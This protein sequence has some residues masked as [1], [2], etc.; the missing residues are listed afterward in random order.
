MDYTVVSQLSKEEYLEWRLYIEKMFHSEQKVKNKK[1][2]YSLMDKD[3]ELAKM[4]LFIFK[5]SIKSEEELYKENK[6]QYEE[7]KQLLE[8]K[9]GVSFNDTVIDEVSFEVKK[10]SSS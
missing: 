8:E 3:L 7:F 2:Q 5:D 6:K 4:K 1:L 10:L 9:H